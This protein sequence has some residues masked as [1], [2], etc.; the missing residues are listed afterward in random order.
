ML[1][2]QATPAKLNCSAVEGFCSSELSMKELYPTNF[3]TAK[4]L[5]Y[6]LFAI[7]FTKQKPAAISKYYALV[8]S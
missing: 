2:D 7:L 4:F 6:R 8:E 5:R 1:A 3:V